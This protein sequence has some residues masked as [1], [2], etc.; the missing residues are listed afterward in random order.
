MDPRATLTPFPRG[1]YLV[2][3]SDDVPIGKVKPVKMM[4]RELVVF[5]TEDGVAHVTNAHCPHFGVHLGHGG[6]VKGD[7]IRCPFHGWEFRASDG[8]CQRIPAGD[9]PPRKARL[10]RWDT[11]EIA[12]LILTWY[13]EEDAA[14]TWRVTDFPSLDDQ[15]Y[16][17]WADYEWTIRARIQD[18]SENDS[19][20][21][22]AP[23]LH[24]FVD[25]PAEV[26][27]Q[28]SGAECKF[29][30][31]AKMHMSAFGVP[32]WLPWLPRDF[33]T[34]ILVRRSGL[35]LGW[36]RQ[37][38]IMPGGFPFHTQTLAA[39]TPIDATHVRLLLRHRVARTRIPVL[40]TLM[41]RSYATMFNRTLEEDIVIW[42]N[43]IY[44]MRPAASK[45]D[46]PILQF[47][48]W[49]R[50]FYPEGHYEAA[51]AAQHP[52]SPVRLADNLADNLAD[53][54]EAVG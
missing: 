19:D 51:L 6:R 4:D 18:L 14:P 10:V 13:H 23:A 24:G 33:S 49:T 5:R 45:S 50:Q 41:L 35:C 31:R 37:E 3:K 53:S 11:H 38:T 30:L 20:V 8:E 36:I 28:V 52:G 1:W 34:D 47:R 48:K 39:T 25:D 2:A 29:R 16:S 7:C 43:K 15:P 44:R 46:A 26:D 32:S 17:E 9:L 12:G 21:S 27:L 40:T 54:A 42:E 22:H